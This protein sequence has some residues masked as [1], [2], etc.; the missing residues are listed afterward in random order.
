V[1]L[2]GRADGSPVDR[3]L[4]AEWRMD[5]EAIA[6][7]LATTREEAEAAV[8]AA[9]WMPSLAR[10]EAEQVLA[11]V[12]I[13]EETAATVVGMCRDLAVAADAERLPD[14][15][16]G[17]LSQVFAAAADAISRQAGA[18]RSNPAE[19]LPEDVTAVQALADASED[20][21][22]QLRELDQTAPLLLG[23]SLLS[24]SDEISRLLTGRGTSVPAAPPPPP[25]PPRRFA[26][27]RRT[28]SPHDA[29]PFR[30][31]PEPTDDV[32]GHRG[33]TDRSASH[34]RP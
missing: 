3:R 21:V 13:H 25:A 15:V 16:A 7:D 32:E 8:A 5:A 33:P 18:A 2:A 23:G 1:A 26:A 30:E 22:S 31:R 24:D 20:A 19:P 28:A 27:R 12:R 34:S 17:P 10:N 11:Q 9:R 29:A 4:V 6:R 14:P